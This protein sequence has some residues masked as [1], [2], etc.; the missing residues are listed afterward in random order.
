MSFDVCVGWCCGLPGAK[1]CEHIVPRIPFGSGVDSQSA[2][3]G[4][5]KKTEN[6]KKCC[7]GRLNIN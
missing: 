6:K 1:Y 4:D 3:C 5:E 2:V 7:D